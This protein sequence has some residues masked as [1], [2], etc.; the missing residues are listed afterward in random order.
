MTNQ[1]EDG[2][3][4]MPV[5]ARD[6]IQGPDDAPLTLIEYGDY[7]CPYCGQA[8]ATVKELQR[9][10]GD[11]LRFVYRNFP[12]TQVH[13]YAEHAA[14]TA[15]AA[16]A[17]DKFWQMHDYL[18]AHQGELD[19]QHLEQYAGAVGLDVSRF[20]TEMRGQTY[21]ERV[22]EDFMSGVESGVGGTPTFFVNG[23]RHDGSFD[24]DALR[25]ALEG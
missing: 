8:D 18:Y 15:E 19:D 5:G 23:R 4:S 9:Q 6:H 16:G 7:Q 13:P 3:L 20:D 10:L 1:D 14:E 22:R 2:T 24:L 25:A 17:Q 11:R 21:L 12:L